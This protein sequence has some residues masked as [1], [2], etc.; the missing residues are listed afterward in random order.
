MAKPKATLQD[1]TRKALEKI[2]KFTADGVEGY[3]KDSAELSRR[4]LGDLTA[5]Y[6]GSQSTGDLE[7]SIKA[8]R[9]NSPLA[10]AVVTD[11]QNQKGH[12]YGAAQEY[13]WH[14]RNGEKRKGRFFI[15]RGTMGMLG[16]WKKGQRWNPEG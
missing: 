5:K 14:K 2:G 10:W 3:S 7:Q 8:Q 11:A 6:P 13:G 1:R 16:R 12:G 4:L 15:I 9:G